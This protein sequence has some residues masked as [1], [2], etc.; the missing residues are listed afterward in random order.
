MNAFEVVV[1][2]DELV[3]DEVAPPP[4]Y[5]PTAPLMLAM[6]PFVGAV[7][8]AAERLFCA[9]CNAACAFAI[10]AF[11]ASRSAGVGPAVVEANVACCVFS[12]AFAESTLFCPV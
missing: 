6:V 4:M 11:E 1:L 10:C 7:S 3:E 2:V 9:V 8:T 5:C 12:A